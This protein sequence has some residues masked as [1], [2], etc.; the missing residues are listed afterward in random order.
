MKEQ[1]NSIN[2]YFLSKELVIWEITAQFSISWDCIFEVCNAAY[3]VHLILGIQIVFKISVQFMVH[4][5]E[6]LTESLVL[7]QKKV[8]NSNRMT[9]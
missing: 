3:N 5:S 8:L 6:T 7:G 2:F 9:R 4:P 1:V